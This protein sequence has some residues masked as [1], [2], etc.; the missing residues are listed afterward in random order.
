V[1]SSNASRLKKWLG[2]EREAR[3]ER[4][5]AVHRAA[6]ALLPDDEAYVVRYVGV[7]AILLA[8]VAHA[9]GLLV[10]AEREHLRALL[11]GCGRVA[12]GRI[13]D[14]CDQL[15]AQVPELSSD[16][17]DACYRELRSLCDAS[18]R[19][20][21]LEILA[22]QALSDGKLAPTEHRVLLE[23]ADAFDIDRERLAAIERALLDPE[24]E[25]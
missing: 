20:R 23:A 4:L 11:T 22:R 25:G 8:R 12:T 14:L 21:I 3:S 6:R 5:A 17:V 15:D 18:Q 16:E 10:H 19:A 7:C 2:L 13:D 24:N 9:D 1:G